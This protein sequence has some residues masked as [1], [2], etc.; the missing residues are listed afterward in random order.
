MED[1]KVQA[2]PFQSENAMMNNLPMAPGSV[3]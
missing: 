3:Q 1:D 2:I